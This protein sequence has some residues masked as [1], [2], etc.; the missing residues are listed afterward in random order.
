M[1]NNFVL[2]L[3]AIRQASQ[4]GCSGAHLNPHG[5]WIPCSSVKQYM[6]LTQP[7]SVKSRTTILEMERRSSRRKKK[8]KRKRKRWENLRERG[9]GGITSTSGVG[10]SSWNG[11]PGKPVGIISGGIIPPMFN[12]NPNPPNVRGGFATK[13][14]EEKT[15]QYS[16]RDNDTDVFIDIESARRRARQLGCIGVSRRTSKS[17][18]I[19][20]MPC[21]NMTDYNNLT[22]MTA[23]GRLNQDKNTQKIV[24]T[25]LSREL[26]KKKKKA[27]SK[28]YLAKRL[29]PRFPVYQD[30]LQEV[31]LRDL[32]PTLKTVTATVCFKTEALLKDPMFLSQNCQRNNQN[33]PQL[34]KKN[35]FLNLQ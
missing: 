30:L 22:G 7:M 23:L 5:E 34:F 31:L 24:R 10:L 26:K 19:V 8:G 20:W 13:S 21:T 18:K 17:G 4:I 35:P 12:G 27:L 15:E 16:P 11:K 6:S 29:V 25:V 33:Q 9:V 1:E 32:T 3:L 28:R 14:L 2:K